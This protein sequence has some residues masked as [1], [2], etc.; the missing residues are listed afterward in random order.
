[1]TSNLSA[2]HFGPRDQKIL[3]ALDERARDAK[4]EGEDT[5]EVAPEDV[6]WAVKWISALLDQ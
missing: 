1:M 4:N 5:I 3:A 6:L 2:R